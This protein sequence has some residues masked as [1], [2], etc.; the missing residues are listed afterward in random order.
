MAMLLPGAED[1]AAH[2]ATGLAVA[3]VYVGRVVQ[4]VAGVLNI[5]PGLYHDICGIRRT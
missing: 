3:R 1:R 5:L 4:Y 2:A